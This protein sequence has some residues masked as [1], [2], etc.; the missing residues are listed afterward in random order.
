[1]GPITSKMMDGTGVVFLWFCLPSRN[2][3]SGD[4]WPRLQLRRWASLHMVQKF[5]ESYLLDEITILYLSYLLL[6]SL[7]CVLSCCRMHYRALYFLCMQPLDH[8]LLA[9]ELFAAV[10]EDKPCQV[11]QIST[12]WME[13]CSLFSWMSWT[14][15]HSSL[16][17]WCYVLWYLN[18]IKWLIQHAYEECWLFLCISFCWDF[19]VDLYPL[20]HYGG[21]PLYFIGWISL[22]SE[23]SCVLERTRSCGIS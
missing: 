20:V 9:K 19:W 1:M 11:V 14:V 6:E 21:D 7:S 2:H 18:V 15:E 17:V 23:W 12:P 4:V 5:R 16:I 10:I 8:V 13:S 22:I 3:G